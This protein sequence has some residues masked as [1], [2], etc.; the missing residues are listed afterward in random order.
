MDFKESAISLD[1]PPTAQPPKPTYPIPN[2]FQHISIM[3]S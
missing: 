2:S 1:D 3:A